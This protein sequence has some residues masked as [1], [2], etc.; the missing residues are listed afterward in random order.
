MPVSTKSDIIIKDYSFNIFSLIVEVL[1]PLM[2]GQHLKR[3][4]ITFAHQRERHLCDVVISPHYRHKVQQN[5][6]LK[7]H[8]IIFMC[9]S[10]G[11]IEF[12]VA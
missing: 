4:L 5:G 6:V 11:I 2:G 7:K 8:R 3:V 9:R 1:I 10:T 12:E